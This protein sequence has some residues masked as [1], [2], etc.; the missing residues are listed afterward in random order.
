LVEKL[1]RQ[2]GKRL[3]VGN[4][5]K[6]FKPSMMLYIPFR[7]PMVNDVGTE[8]DQI[9]QIVDE[10]TGI[11]YEFLKH[12]RYNSIIVHYT[13]LHPNTEYRIKQYTDKHIT[14]EDALKL[15]GLSLDHFE[16][17]ERDSHLGLEKILQTK[18]RD[19]PLLQGTIKR[20]PETN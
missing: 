14:L 19:L 1:K 6:P 12:S 17:F 11:C 20:S 2:K 3:G 4:P 18:V 16:L 15:L 9:A 13:T 7:E 10:N 5:T 8:C